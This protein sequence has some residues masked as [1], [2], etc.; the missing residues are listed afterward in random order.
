[1]YVYVHVYV[2]VYVCISVC[3]HLTV[4]RCVSVSMSHLVSSDFMIQQV[5]EQEVIHE[6]TKVLTDACYLKDNS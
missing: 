6:V 1:M 4:Y 3:V 5:Q 2:S